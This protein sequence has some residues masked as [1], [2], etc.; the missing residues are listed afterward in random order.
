MR[1]KREGLWAVGVCA[2]S[3]QEGCEMAGCGSMGWRLGVLIR[4][5]GMS[6]L[7]EV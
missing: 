1:A 5:V 2:G 4:P 3:R 7:M 6:F